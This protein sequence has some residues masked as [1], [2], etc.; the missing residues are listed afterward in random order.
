MGLF[1]GAV[2]SAIGAVGSLIGGNQASNNAAALANMNYKAQKEFAQNGIRWKVADAKAAGIHPLYALGSSPASFTPVQGYTG[3]NGI[4]DAFAHF[5]QGIS[6]AVQAKMTK[7][8]REQLAI[9]Q[10]IQD[11]LML[12]EYRQRSEKNRAEIELLK[13]ET[14]RNLAASKM[15]L[16]RQ[17]QVPS[18]PSVGVPDSIPGQGDKT[19]DYGGNS[20]QVQRD[21]TGKEGIFP[22]NDYNQVYED[23]FILEYL[24][25]WQAWK[26]ERA[27]K[28]GEVVG[29]YVWDDSSGRVVSVASPSGRA[30]LARRARAAAKESVTKQ[31]MARSAPWMYYR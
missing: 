6:R 13:S 18:M 10:A 2:G 9:K 17:S 31:K 20:F 3:D 24:P 4:S 22:T 19:L 5:G 16:S 25:N 26:A 7:E 1:S 11:S 29:G 23:K 12:D 30:V 15:A 21:I 8:E 14:A 28:N 27:L